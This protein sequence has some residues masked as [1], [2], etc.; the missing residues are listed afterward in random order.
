[1]IMVPPNYT[2]SI[3]A[4]VNFS[5]P[6]SFDTSTTVVFLS[7]PQYNATFGNWI[8]VD[9]GAGGYQLA[10]VHFAADSRYFSYV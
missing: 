6:F 1:M 4:V 8:E 7:V 9:G 3:A 5:F 2:G 10:F